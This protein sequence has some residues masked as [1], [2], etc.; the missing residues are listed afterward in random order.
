MQLFF[1]DYTGQN[2][3]PFWEVQTDDIGDFVKLGLRKSE[4]NKLILDMSTINKNTY[5]IYYEELNKS[6]YYE[7]NLYLADTFP[8]EIDEKNRIYSAFPYKD[9]FLDDE[10]IEEEWELVNPNKHPYSKLYQKL[11]PDALVGMIEVIHFNQPSL[12]KKLNRCRLIG[13]SYINFPKT[14]F[15]DAGKYFLTR[16]L[17]V[18]RPGDVIYFNI[19]VIRDGE[20][21]YYNNE[22]I[23][24]KNIKQLLNKPTEK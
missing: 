4:L 23:S 22:S 19:K 2:C 10:K 7:S 15:H 18:L 14:G 11:H 13:F 21:V 1:L 9:T 17:V 5:N 20:S 3:L 6:A 12:I 24:Y 16:H 8:P